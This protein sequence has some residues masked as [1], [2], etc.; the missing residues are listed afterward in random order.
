[1]EI[2]F[3]EK[4]KQLNEERQKIIQDLKTVQNA[5][6]Q[7]A[8]RKLKIDAKIEQLQELKGEEDESLAENIN[9]AQEGGV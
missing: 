6:N 2:N 8:A 3:D 7:L 4:I 9:E 1:V 5:L